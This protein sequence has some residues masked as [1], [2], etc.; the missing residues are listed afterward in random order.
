M[1]QFSFGRSLT[2]TNVP[3]GIEVIYQVEVKQ[4]SFMMKDSFAYQA[5]LLF[6]T[7]PHE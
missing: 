5:V 1:R 2:S 7:P 4:I 3:L 6:K